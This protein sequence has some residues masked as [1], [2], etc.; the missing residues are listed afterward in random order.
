M[1][2]TDDSIKMIALLSVSH[3]AVDFLCAF[4]L[5]RRF[6]DLPEVFLLYNFCAFALQLPLGTMIDMWI[7]KRGELSYPCLVYVYAGVLLTV[8]G[9]MISPL[10][11]GLGNALFHSG[12][13]VL[14]IGEDRHADMKGK[15][16]GVFV[17]PGALGLAC[18]LLFYGTDVYNAV[19]YA[20][21]VLLAVFCLMMSRCR[22][23]RTD[24]P[25]GKTAPHDKK[26]VLVALACFA[27]VIVR[28]LCGMAVVFPWRNGP[29]LILL[30]TLFLAAGKTAGG[31]FAAK[32]GMKLT[33]PL[34][35]ALAAVSYCFADKAIFGLA[36]LFFFNMTMPLT[37]YM[38][39]EEMPDLP[40]TAFG[41]LTFG[42][43]LGYLPVLYGFFRSVPP[44]PAG[45]LFSNLSLII[46]G[47]TVRMR[48]KDG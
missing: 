3:M 28:S 11:T 25:D 8:C 21:S 18:G 44:F 42:L 23:E 43:F 7:R 4:S 17:A 48:E 46:L 13:G 39:A 20:V 41:L 14:T 10:V 36:A 5:F 38:L 2:K 30:S 1:T 35:L 12:G 27:V 9:T 33:V 37:L 31:F 45:A 6:A 29:A 34:T 32:Y 16:L 40:G 26:T 15:G 19:I 47:Y 22:K 24:L